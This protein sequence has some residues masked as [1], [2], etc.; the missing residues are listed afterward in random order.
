MSGVISYLSLYL[1]ILQFY[2]V[3]V[4]VKR[5]GGAYGG[6]ITRNNILASAC[7]LAAYLTNRYHHHKNYLNYFIDI[8]DSGTNLFISKLFYYA[9][10]YLKE[11]IVDYNLNIPLTN[12]P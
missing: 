10:K 6:K 4:E 3:S 2:R 5:V 7:G 1:H 11:Y 8:N 9:T 12:I